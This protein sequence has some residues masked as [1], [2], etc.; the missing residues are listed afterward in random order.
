MIEYYKSKVATIQA[1]LNPHGAD[2][3]GQESNRDG[4]MSCGS[5][6]AHNEEDQASLVPWGELEI[7]RSLLQYLEELKRDCLQCFEAQNET[8]RQRKGTWLSP[9][10]A[11]NDSMAS[12]A[13]AKQLSAV[14]WRGF[15]DKG[16]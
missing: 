3:G 9:S 5:A 12:I 1:C 8:V 11:S 15:R 10:G 7:R 2:V 4:D 14:V 13:S 16:A 6:Q